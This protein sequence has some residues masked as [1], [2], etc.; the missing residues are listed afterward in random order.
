MSVSAPLSSRRPAWLAIMALANAG[1]VLAYLPLL[2]LLLPI[3]IQ[4]MNPAERIGLFAATAVIGAIAASIANIVFGGLSDRSHARGGRW[5]RR[6]W[7][8]AGLVAI[9]ASYAVLAQAT[10]PAT[11]IGAIVLFQ[12]AVN[13]LLAPL[14]AVIAE[15]V[16]D[17]QKGLA[18]G[19]IALGAPL[20]SGASALLLGMP[21]LSSDARLAVIPVAV[22]LCVA[23]LLLTRARS[24]VVA[25]PAMTQGTAAPPRR[26]LIVAGLSRLLVQV[27]AVVTQAYLLY[28]FES[29]MPAAEHRGL[30][31]RIGHLMAW[32]FLAPL[33]AAL[34]LGRL[35]D[36]TRRRTPILLFAAGVAAAGLLGMAAAEGWTQGALAYA[37]YAAGSSVFV[38]LQA[39][40]AM[41][42]L[43]D[44]RRRGR[45]LGLLNLTNTLPSLLGP[46]LAWLFATPDDFAA[47]MIG[48]AILTAVG[49]T[50]MLGVRAWR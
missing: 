3:R 11:L 15:E 46:P 29:I 31:V 48:L 10:T 44:P 5:G 47:V 33:P 49:G 24:A 41:Q 7:M 9:A 6:G 25:V 2:T 30:P 23:P 43:P 8:A 37:V 13:A 12:I 27:A 1:G 40:F 34:V 18:G 42:L 26:D 50:L 35:S 32:T 45:D 20:A 39:T 36:L 28:Y 4:A 17:A 19:L 22:A 38:A 21:T 16:P 14:S